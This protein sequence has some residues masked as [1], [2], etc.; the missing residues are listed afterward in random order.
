MLVKSEWLAK[1]A[2]KQMYGDNLSV[3]GGP[4]PER[5][6]VAPAEVTVTGSS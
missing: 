4:E 6:P 1:S 3:D 5:Q 2:S